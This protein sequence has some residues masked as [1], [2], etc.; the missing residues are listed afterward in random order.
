MIQAHLALAGAE[1]LVDAMPATVRFDHARQRYLRHRVRQRVP[2]ARLTAHRADDDQTLTAAD[3]LP[4]RPSSAPTPPGPTPLSGPWNPRPNAAF[5]S[6]TS[7]EPG[8]N[9][10]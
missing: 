4:P 9:H 3:T 6:A 8:T 2:A 5:A 10:R 7:A 1:K